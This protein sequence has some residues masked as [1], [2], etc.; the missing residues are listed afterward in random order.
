MRN[1]IY[2]DNMNTTKLVILLTFISWI[3]ISGQ[4]VNFNKVNVERVLIDSGEFRNYYKYDLGNYLFYNGRYENNLKFQVQE[5]KNHKKVL[6]HSNT[7][8]DALI[9]KPKF[10]MTPN[11]SII[12]IMVEVAAEYSWGQE[13]ILIKNKKIKYLG[14]LDYAVDL[15]NGLSISD[16]CNFSLIKNKVFLTFDNVPIVYWPEESNKIFGKDLKFELSDSIM[17]IK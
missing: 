9:L 8:S 15:E 3:S 10:F 5:K 6:D 2:T 1:P 4:P 17:K 12:V 7:T 13:L 11:K 16:Y 14:Y